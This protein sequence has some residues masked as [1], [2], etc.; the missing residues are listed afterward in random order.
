MTK[1]IMIKVKKYIYKKMKKLSEADL[2]FEDGSK[3]DI[4]VRYILR[5]KLLRGSDR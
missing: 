5:V 2:K 4:T 3:T 1:I